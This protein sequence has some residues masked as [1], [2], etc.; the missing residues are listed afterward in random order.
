MLNEWLQ[1]SIELANAG[2]YLDK[3]FSVYPITEN[4]DRKMNEKEWNLVENSFNNNND[5][6]LLKSL[7]KLPLFPLKNSSGDIIQALYFT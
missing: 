5:D 6:E 1:K 3:L 4:D 2:C 7:F